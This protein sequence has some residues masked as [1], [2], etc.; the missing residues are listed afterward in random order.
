MCWVSLFLVIGMQGRYE[1]IH[2]RFKEIDLP[3]SFIESCY[4]LTE[5]QLELVCTVDHVNM[6]DHRDQAWKSVAI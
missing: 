6:H 3:K 5:I 2:N 4:A 1:F